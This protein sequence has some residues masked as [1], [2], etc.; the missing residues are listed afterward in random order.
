MKTLLVAAVCLIPAG[1]TASQGGLETQADWLRDTAMARFEHGDRASAL[2]IN[3][4]ALRLTRRLPETSRRTVENYDDAGLYYFDAAKWK[5]SAQ[6]QAV[7]VLLSCGVAES[8]SMF[9]TYVERLGWAFAK[10]RPHEDFAPIAENPLSLLKDTSLNARKYYDLR[11]RYFRTIKRKPVSP[12]GPAQY[13]YRLRPET[14]P[15]SCY[16]KPQQQALGKTMEP[17]QAQFLA[18]MAPEFLPDFYH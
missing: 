8:E 16:A 17:V 12:G 3:R 4:R 11:R 10:Y 5:T 13:L 15:E 14:L 9:P 18:L 7:A 1:A 6:H 2:K